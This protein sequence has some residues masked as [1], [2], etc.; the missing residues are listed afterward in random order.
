MRW[1]NSLHGDDCLD[2][3]KTQSADFAKAAAFIK[4]SAIY[5]TRI[6]LAQVRMEM[7]IQP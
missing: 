6:W 1:T 5:D 4:C 2:M 7:I 3:T